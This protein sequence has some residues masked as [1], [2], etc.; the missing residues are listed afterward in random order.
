MDSCLQTALN[1]IRR[2]TEGMTPDQL[3]WHPDGKWSAAQILDHLTLTF[4]GTAKAMERALSGS[5]T[6]V[7]KRT[8]KSRLSALIVTE[9]GYFPSGRKSPE[10]VLPQKNDGVNAVA[11]IVKELTG[12][13]AVFTEIERKKGSMTRVPHPVIGPLTIR[14]WRRFHRAHTRHH[15]KQVVALRA[16]QQS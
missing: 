1:E 4:A 15:M 8:L 14:Q 7:Q 9:I 10:M 13:D 6:G 5:E 16:M 11:T 12:M 3:T 2:A